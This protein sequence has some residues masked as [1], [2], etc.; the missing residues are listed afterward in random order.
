MDDTRKM[1]RAIINGQSAFK[2]EFLMKIDKVD[3]KV[4]KVDAKIDGLDKK[5]GGAEKNLSNR[6]DKLGL[7]L[8]QLED[9]APTREEH[10]MLDKR[11]SNVEHKIAS[12]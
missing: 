1:L 6:L 9:D 11:V 12:I 7:Q 3:K 10:D 4:D 2:Q 5:I 8:A